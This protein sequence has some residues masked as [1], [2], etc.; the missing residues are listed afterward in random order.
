MDAPLFVGIDVSK[1][2]L[3]VAVLP[4]GEAWTSPNDPDGVAALVARV[5]ELGPVLV[6]LEAT[7]RYEAACAAA[8]ATDGMPVAVVNPRQARDFAKATGRLA[9]TDALDAAVLALFAERVRPEPRPLPDAE[10]EALAA[11]LAR[12]RQLITMLV[13][14]KNRAHVA[15]KAVAKSVAKH[16][17]WLERE[18]SSASSRARALGRRRRPQR[19]DPRERRLAGQGRLTPERARRRPRDGDD[20][21]GGAPGARPAHAA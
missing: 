19:G 16:V 15:P 12:R 3:N 1:S 9:K 6:V 7:G 20:A 2:T 14:E 4:T 21:L 8:L 17:R 11:I 13:S 10:S 18:L 5:A